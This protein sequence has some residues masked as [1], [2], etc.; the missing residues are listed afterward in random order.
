M[1]KILPSI[2]T[3]VSRTLGEVLL[4]LLNF[5]SLVKVFFLI[6]I[7]KLFI[8]SRL[9]IIICIP[10]YA[11]IIFIKN[12]TKGPKYLLKLTNGLVAK[13]TIAKDTKAPIAPYAISPIVNFCIFFS[14]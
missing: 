12:T 11:A 7:N 6:F 4:L 1:S 3:D 9:F 10:I 5:F 14:I 8:S 13:P 2:I